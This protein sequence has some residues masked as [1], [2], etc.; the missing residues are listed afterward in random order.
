MGIVPIRDPLT[1]LPARQR[2]LAKRKKSR[3]HVSAI[4]P[5][6]AFLALDKAATRFLA[7][8]FLAAGTAKKPCTWKGDCQAP[9][10]H[11]TTR[12][13]S[14]ASLIALATEPERV[15]KHLK[16][17]LLVAF[18]QHKGNVLSQKSVNQQPMLI[19]KR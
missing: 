18:V 2:S 10:P 16:D 5:Q 6:H 17:M 15:P 13:V 8:G 7:A 1:C 9:L 4:E 11:P 3:G 12:S 19:P 14:T